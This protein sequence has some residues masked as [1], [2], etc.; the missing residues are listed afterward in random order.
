MTI[1]QIETLRFISLACYIAAGLFLVAAIILF[2][3]MD[4]PKVYGEV[5]GK[6]AKKAISAMKQRNIEGVV[7]SSRKKIISEPGQQTSAVTAGS[8]PS[9][10]SAAVNYSS[11][12]RGGTRPLR[13]EDRTPSD[14]MPTNG[15]TRKLGTAPVPAVST[16]SLEY[17]VRFTESVETIA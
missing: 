3:V 12:V 2:F 8:I 16:L 15:T 10:N 13:P 7:S 17:E 9:Q 1:E 4:V 11:S 6:T 14:S 5:T